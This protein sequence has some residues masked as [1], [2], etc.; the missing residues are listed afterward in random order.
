MLDAD[1]S[2]LCSKLCR[3]NVDNPTLGSWERCKK[4]ESES[5]K[6]GG[7]LVSL[8]P[9]RISDRPPLTGES[10]EQS[11][12]TRFSNLPETLWARKSISSSSLSKR[13]SAVYSWNLLYEEN[14]WSY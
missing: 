3:H 5:Q 6:K 2:L 11:P 12:G 14:L 13:K 9:T 7:G 8:E 1:S 10:S 4:Q